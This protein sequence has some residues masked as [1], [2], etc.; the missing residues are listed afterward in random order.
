MFKLFS[1]IKE[2]NSMVNLNKIIM[3]KKIIRKKYHNKI[4]ILKR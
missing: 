2:I 1:L 3:K 4:N